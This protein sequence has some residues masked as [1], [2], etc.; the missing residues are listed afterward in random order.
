MSMSREHLV[1]SLLELEPQL[2]ARGVTHLALFGSRAR[3]DNRP[4]S[5]VDVAIEVDP[6]AKFSLI[7]LVGVEREIRNKTSLPGN[8]FMRRS[9]EPDFVTSLARDGIN[10]F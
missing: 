8:V 7:D 6:H 3:Q 4:D 9:L 10:V 2:R 1:Q 5:D